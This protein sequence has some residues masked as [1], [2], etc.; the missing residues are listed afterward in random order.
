MIL[1]SIFCG[2]FCPAEHV[3]PEDPKYREELKNIE[4]LLQQLSQK[5]PPEDYQIVESILSHYGT[6]E[7]IECEAHFKFGF[8]AGL[9]LQQE[10]Q[11]Q[12]QNSHKNK[13]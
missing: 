13:T 9:T 12:L 11:S 4:S 5:L 1:E 3:Y 2:S 8:S 6:V 7:S 10:A